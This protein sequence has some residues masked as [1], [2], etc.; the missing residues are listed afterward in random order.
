MGS[1]DYDRIAVGDEIPSLTWT[2]GMANWN[3]YAVRIGGFARDVYED[4]SISTGNEGRVKGTLTDC[5]SNLGRGR[6]RR[7]QTL[8]S[9]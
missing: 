6:V 8:G 3:R 1:P 2:T 7:P 5:R 4:D 9:D